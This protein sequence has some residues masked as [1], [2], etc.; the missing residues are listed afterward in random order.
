MTRLA[1]L[2]LGSKLSLQVTLAVAVVLALLAFVVQRQ[3]SR[4]IQ[5]RALA[6]LDVAAQVMLESV[7]L[8]DS[9]LSEATQRMARAF[10]ASLPSGDVSVILPPARPSAM[11]RCRRCASASRR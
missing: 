6:D 8:Y 2:S 10:R 9:T 5:D 4:A 7:A 11:S 1:R 3:S